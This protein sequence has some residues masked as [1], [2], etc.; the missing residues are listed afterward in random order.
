MAAGSQ[1]LKGTCALLVK[2]ATL[3]RAHHL[4]AG[5]SLNLLNSASLEEVNLKITGIE[6]RIR[7]SPTRFL[8]PVNRLAL[9]D[10]LLL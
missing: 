9:Y 6:I 4:I 2:A 1:A 3:N 10:L 8:K 5:E 7:A